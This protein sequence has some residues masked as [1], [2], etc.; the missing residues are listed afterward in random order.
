MRAAWITLLVV[1]AALAVWPMVANDY[2]IVLTLRALMYSLVVL[3]F[4]LLAGQLGLVSLLQT[5]FAGIA[6]Y[7]VAILGVTYGWTFP[8][9]VLAAFGLALISALVFA[10]IS[11]RASGIGFMMLTL[12]L[13]QMVWA[14]SF[15]WVDLTKGMDGI[16]GVRPPVILGL[17][18]GDSHA[19]YAV[20]APIVVLT[21][22]AVAVLIHSRF[23]LLM[24]GI[25]DNVVRMRALGYPVLKC[26]LTA[27]LL[28]SLIAAAGG[29]LL[30]WDTRVMTPMGLDLSRAVWV[31]TAAVVGGYRYLIGVPIGVTV[32]V[33]LEAVLN[34]YTDRHLMVFGIV[35]AGSILLLP[36]GIAA[37]IDDA[38]S[39][40]RQGERVMRPEQSG[41]DQGGAN[42]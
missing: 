2:L 12:A 23:G 35:L 19:L 29:I 27:F 1:V 38:R 13:G 39:K 31:L 8:W 42:V 37:L 24:R 41:Q 15:Q 36:N 18:L 25:Q 32:M 4:S 22:A 5:T 6:G 30:A 11:L 10:L 7:A 33:I 28:A 40:L 9:T 34:Q 16:A 3:S 26:R 17:D 21:F 20:T 14:L